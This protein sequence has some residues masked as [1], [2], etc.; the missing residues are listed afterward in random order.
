M[1]ISLKYKLLSMR[2]E[3]NTKLWERGFGSTRLN[4]IEIL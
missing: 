1:Y 4:A 3:G 2:K